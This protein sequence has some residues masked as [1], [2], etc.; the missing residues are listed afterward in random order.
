MAITTVTG[1]TWDQEV[2]AFAETHGLVDLLPKLVEAVREIF[3]D[4]EGLSVYVE[5]DPEIANER[6]LILDVVD[7]HSS[8][9]EYMRRIDQWHQALF[10]LEGSPHRCLVVLRVRSIS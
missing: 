3:P 9:D 10:R 2:Q 4:Q 6:S 1:I 8:L 5:D 7:P